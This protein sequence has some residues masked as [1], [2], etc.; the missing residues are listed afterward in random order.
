M[1][2]LGPSLHL[3]L[4]MGNEREGGSPS[5]TPRMEKMNSD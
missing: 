2:W 3:P 1:C 4:G 5:L